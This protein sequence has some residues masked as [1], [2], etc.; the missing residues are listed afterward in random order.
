MSA[1]TAI[2]SSLDSW[3]RNPAPEARRF[4]HG[5]GHLHE[6]LEHIN[7]DWYPPLL[8][9]SAYNE[10]ES[11]DELKTIIGEADV[12]SQVG[13]VILQKRYVKGAPSST[14][15]GPSQ[16]CC[17]VIEGELKFE[18]HPGVQQNAGLF[19][20][21]RPLR[22]WLRLNSEGKNLL[23]LFAYTCSF[24]VAALAG[25]ARQVVNVDM[26]KPSI[27]W[28]ERN[29]AIN[30]QDSRAVRSIPHNLF[31]SWG[32]IRK[33]GPYHTIIVDPPSRQR[34]SFDA[35]KNY[36]A[37]L[38]RLPQLAH[39]GADI[40]ATINSPYLNSDFLIHQV[41]RYAPQCSLYKEIPA[42]PEFKDKFPDK[43]LKIF[44]FKIY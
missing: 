24:S 1:Y 16:T 30:Q 42:S 38:K 44:H 26:S 18:V 41:Q 7:I 32:R 10:I 9:I 4:F 6:G 29:H 13:T 35:E 12:L 8:L 15:F 11:V 40:I 14:I 17:I 33:Y 39:P 34:G 5:R 27:K 36:G 21:M 19:L 3:L 20:D 2:K 23:N 37:V 31:R 22:Q 43:A 25:G 28:G